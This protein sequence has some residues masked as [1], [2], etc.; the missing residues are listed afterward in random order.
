[1]EERA[2]GVNRNSLKRTDVESIPTS[3]GPDRD[4]QF[5]DFQD[6]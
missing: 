5:S 6:S 3:G 4:V 2:V 1:M